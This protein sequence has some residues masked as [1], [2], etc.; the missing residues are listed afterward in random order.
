MTWTSASRA[1]ALQLVDPVRERLE[2][3]RGAVEGGLRLAVP[4]QVSSSRAG[5]PG[6]R[7]IVAVR[8]AIPAAMTTASATQTRPVT[9]LRRRLTVEERSG[10]AVRAPSGPT[11]GPARPYHRRMTTLDPAAC[12]P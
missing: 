9:K 11:P 6:V 8:P 12:A 2:L 3:D 7:F 5:V 1:V 4:D 10:P